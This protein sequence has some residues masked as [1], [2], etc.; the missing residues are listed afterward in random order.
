MISLVLEFKQNI[1]LNPGRYIL[2]LLHL[3]LMRLFIGEP[4]WTAYNRPQEDHPV[5]QE[6]VKNVKGDTGFALAAHWVCWIGGSLYNC[7]LHHTTQMKSWTH[8]VFI[9][10]HENTYAVH[11]KTIICSTTIRLSYKNFST[12]WNIAVY[13]VTGPVL[14]CNVLH[15][16]LS[17]TSRLD[18]L[19]KILLCIPFG[20]ALFYLTCCDWSCSFHFHQSWIG[21]WDW[22]GRGALFAWSLRCSLIELSWQMCFHLILYLIIYFL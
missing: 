1:Y 3:Q 9:M 7:P 4:V 20:N 17:I 19:M 5:R 6:Y 18:T 12:T 16:K 11:L 8:A 14:L 2:I 21:T 10:N 13:T 22:E 15:Q